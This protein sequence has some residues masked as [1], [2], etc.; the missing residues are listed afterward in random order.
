MPALGRRAGICPDRSTGV[1]GIVASS[2]VPLISVLIGALITYRLNVRLRKHAHVE[3][4]FNEA[5]SAVAV[6]EANKVYPR[7]WQAVAHAR[8]GIPALPG[9]CTTGSYA[10]PSQAR[11]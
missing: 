10:E 2:I 7:G 9:G 4:R 6:A 1:F 5:I 3:D 11:H 8:R